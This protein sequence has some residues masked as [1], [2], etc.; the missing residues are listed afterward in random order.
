VFAVIVAILTERLIQG[1]FIQYERERVSMFLRLPQWWGYLAASVAS[2]VWSAV[3]F[4]TAW[5][6]LM[7]AFEPRK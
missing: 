7:R 6:S 1:T 2:L 5:E 3:T 4:Y